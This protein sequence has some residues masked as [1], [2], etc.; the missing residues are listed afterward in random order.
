[1]VNQRLVEELS[2]KASGRNKVK[3]NALEMVKVMTVR[4][5]NFNVRF[6][7]VPEGNKPVSGGRV[8]RWNT[9]APSESHPSQCVVTHS[10]SHEP[11]CDQWD[12]EKH[13]ASTAERC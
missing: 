8:E 5:R 2:P 13:E 9:P 6:I 7:R 1:M 10:V 3:K 11:Y 4:N 12:I